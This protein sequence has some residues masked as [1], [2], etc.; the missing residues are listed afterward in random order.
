MK[1]IAI[2]NN[3][4]RVLGAIHLEFVVGVVCPTIL[5]T[6]YKPPKWLLEYEETD[7]DEYDR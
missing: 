7:S 3:P 5:A 2:L 6:D 1:K 4:D